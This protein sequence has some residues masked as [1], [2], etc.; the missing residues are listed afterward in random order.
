MDTLIN[1]ALN[2]FNTVTTVTLMDLALSTIC[3]FV[4]SMIV[5]RTY[6]A[7]HS[8]YSYSRS[9][10]IALVL[11]CVTITLIMIIIG[12]NIARAFA[13]VGAM[14]IVRFR[15][16]VKDSRDLVYIF[17]AIAIGMAS[18]TQFYSFAILFTLFVCAVSLGFHHSGFGIIKS[19]NYVLRIRT[20]T[21][22]REAIEELCDRY[23]DSF[24]VVSLDRFAGDREIEEIV[25]EIEL[26][27]KTTYNEFVKNISML[28][29]NISISLLV[30]E[31]MVDA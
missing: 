1:E 2:D 17:M 16:P 29:Q 24:F 18:G 4:L 13:L 11:V 8:G 25:Y 12:S 10:T 3:S 22:A 27:K 15:N 6:I 31:Q 7:T 28:S 30:G 20:P 9:F 14:S 26:R 21:T 5:A 23:C 19:R